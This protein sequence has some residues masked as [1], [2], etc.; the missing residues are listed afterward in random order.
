ME[1][2]WETAIR[3]AFEQTVIAR[4]TFPRLEPRVVGGPRFPSWESGTNWA[5]AQKTA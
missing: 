1:E 3:L 2:R 4:H 5:V